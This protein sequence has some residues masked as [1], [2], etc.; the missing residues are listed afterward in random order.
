MDIFETYLPLV[1]Q[2]AAALAGVKKVPNVEPL[3]KKVINESLV[4]LK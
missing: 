2:N 4:E 1:A 3:I